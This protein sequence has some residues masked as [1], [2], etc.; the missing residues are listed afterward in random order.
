MKKE[1][2]QY[3]GKD[4]FESMLKQQKMSL[5]DYKEQKKLQAYQK[6]LLNDKV[7]ISDKEI[8]EDTEKGSHML[9]KVKEKTKM[10]KKVYQIKMLK[11]KQKKS[12]NKLKKIQINLAKLLKN[13]WINLQL[14][15]MVA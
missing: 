6:E 13:Q 12:K 11:L 9:I 10:I 2:K 7:D 5:G 15:K 3:G 14:K 1:Q 4:Q 8:K